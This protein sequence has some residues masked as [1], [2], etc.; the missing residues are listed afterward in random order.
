MD[1]WVLVRRGG[2]HPRT[3]FN[4]GGWG[5][6]GYGEWSAR[7]PAFPSGRGGRAQA[8]LPNPPAPRPRALRFAGPQTRSYAD[9]VRQPRPQQPRR[10]DRPRAQETDVRRQAAEPQFGRLVRKLHQVIKMVHHLQNVSCKPGN[11]EP[12]MIARMVDLLSRMI[13]PALPTQRTLDFIAGNARNWGHTTR[14]VLM[15]HYEEGIEELLVQLANMLT[16]DWKQA[17]QVATRWA[18]RNLRR[19][20]QEVVDHAEALVTARLDS[21]DPPLDPPP[22]PAPAAV[23]NRSTRGTSPMVDLGDLLQPR[24][25]GRVSPRPSTSTAAMVDAVT[26]AASQ[27][28]LVLESTPCQPAPRS[29][30]KERR[31]TI[32]SRLVP[33]LSPVD[34]PLV[35]ETQSLPV[36]A[37][38][39]RTVP[40][41][42]TRGVSF[43]TLF[44]E[45]EEELDP[46]PQQQ[47]VNVQVHRDPSQDR[48]LEERVEA[49][50]DAGDE[51]EDIFEDSSDRFTG[52]A[53]PRFKPYRHPNTQRKLT[54][55]S[56]TVDK[57]WLIIGD[58]NVSRFPDYFNPDL[59]VESFPGAHFRHGQALMEKTDPPQDLVVEK[60]VLS[61]GMNSRSNKSKET[62]VKNMQ[63]ALRSAR[64]K[65]PYADVYVPLINYSTALPQ[66]EQTN[67]DTLNDHIW[68]N[69]PHIPLLPED[70]FQTELDDV[71]WTPETASAILDHWV[72]F[73]NSGSP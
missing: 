62:T 19:L 41:A 26:E 43:E 50:V 63:G 71:H 3:H 42:L 13:K 29:P 30:R 57:K 39:Q 36:G 24:T 9:V 54:D 18:R 25:A 10:R 23:P 68:R 70:R 12:R 17:F 7:A 15:D 28:P 5:D 52:P 44:P 6:G 38:A 51:E 16:P 65:F 2:R 72:A 58:S 35:C 56:L 45:E 53:P 49:R 59:Q 67:L 37:P 20:T 11:P 48:Q 14:L 47:V 66:E 69:T 31:T 61:F 46:A 40:P 73:L 33:P 8:P 22:R 4:D 21:A 32:R 1:D 27:V 64:R 34:L 60:I 55:W